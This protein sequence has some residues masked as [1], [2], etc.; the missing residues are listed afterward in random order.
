MKS[1]QLKLNRCSNDLFHYGREEV[2]KRKEI[3]GQENF[4][5]IFETYTYREI[6]K[7]HIGLSKL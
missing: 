1:L 4:F 7:S 3:L 5:V 6:I 2:K